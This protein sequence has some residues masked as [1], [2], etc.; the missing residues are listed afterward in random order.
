[1]ARR[2]LW[3]AALG[4]MILVALPFVVPKP[5]PLESSPSAGTTIVPLSAIVA[6]TAGFKKVRFPRDFRFPADHGPHPAYPSE[7]WH[8]A[9][10]LR[11]DEGRPLGFQLTLI[12]RSLG[13]AAP[14]RRSSWAAHEVYAGVFS[15]SLP[16]A[17]LRSARRLSRAA[18]GL[19]G[20]RAEPLRIWLEDWQLDLAGSAGGT[21]QGALLLNGNDLSL[22]LDFGQPGQGLI[23]ENAFDGQR[24]S[25]ARPPFHLYLQPRLQAAGVLRGPDGEQAVRGLITLEHAWGE[26][27]LPG[28]PVAFDRFTLHLDDGRALYAF[29]R[30]RVGEGSR[31]VTTGFF[32]DRDGRARLL[33]REEIALE[34]AAYWNSPD[35][36]ARYPVRWRL[37]V[38][39]AGIDMELVPAHRAQEGRAWIPYWAGLVVL[40]PV[41]AGASPGGA[42]MVQLYGYEGA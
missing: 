19:A 36:G 5:A 4:I 22:Q 26:L 34:P 17:P 33:G 16:D 3:A 25:R 7:W 32:I 1:M 27:P 12:R 24:A 13:P 40:R 15:L 20:T 28:G 14:A 30:H 10:T 11:D 8:L 21:L 37:R 29:R 42:G 6:E 9:G 18:A 41:A 23:D 31:A 38:A 2:G 39:A 35:S